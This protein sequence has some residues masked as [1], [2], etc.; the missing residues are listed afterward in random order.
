L[1][2]VCRGGAILVH[3]LLEQ[4]NTY[5]EE[6]EQFGICL[7]KRLGVEALYGSGITRGRRRKSVLFGG[8]PM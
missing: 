5:D 3:F 8:D 4:Q 2:G 7:W 6:D 1:I